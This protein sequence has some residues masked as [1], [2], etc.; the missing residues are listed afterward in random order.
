MARFTGKAVLVTGGT[1]GIGEAAAEAFD[2]EGAKVVVAGRGVQAQASTGR[3]YQMRMRS[4]SSKVIS[5]LVRS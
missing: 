3:G 2:R 4:I 1:S 5:S